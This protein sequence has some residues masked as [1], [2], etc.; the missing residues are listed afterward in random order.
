MHPRHT[1][2][3]DGAGAAPNPEPGAELLQVRHEWRAV[4]GRSRSLRVPH[5]R[6][7]P[8]G[9]RRQRR[10]R[11][12]SGGRRWPRS[13]PSSARS[14][15]RSR[16][17]SGTSRGLTDYSTVVAQ[18]PSHGV[19]GVVV[20][21]PSV[22]LALAGADPQ[23]RGNLA[24]KVVL[25][26]VEPGPSPLP[27]RRACGRDHR[28]RPESP[29]AGSRRPARPRPKRPIPDRVHPRVSEDPEVPEGAS[30]TFRTT[31]R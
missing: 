4:D 25:T 16:S 21:F 19:D 6:L 13:T 10:S 1:T 18:V 28:C 22:L 14:E 17:G 12:R 3:V 5:A 2:F 26:S 15:G 27:A 20:D 24:R 29:A 30:S 9:D 8:C 23:L 7:A 31:T 11:T